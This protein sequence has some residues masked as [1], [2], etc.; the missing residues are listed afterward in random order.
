MR[1][2]V[3][4]IWQESPP[5]GSRLQEPYTEIL[6]LRDVADTLGQEIV[7]L[8]ESIAKGTAENARLDDEWRRRWLGQDVPPGLEPL[9]LAG[10]CVAANRREYVLRLWRSGGLV[11]SDRAFAWALGLACVAGILGNLA[12][13]LMLTLGW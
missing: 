10:Q 12:G 8:R 2:Y 1:W 7:K 4:G 13:R 6:R 5:D 3:N 11:R 9:S